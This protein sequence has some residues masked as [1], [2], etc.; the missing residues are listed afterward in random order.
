M[1]I[2]CGTDLS[3]D[4]RRSVAAADALARRFRAKLDLVHVMHRSLADTMAKAVREMH[5]EDCRLGLTELAAMLDDDARR[6]KTRLLTGNADEEL[7]RLGSG[8]DALFLVVGS[9]GHRGQGHWR[10]GSCA[11]RVAETSHT[12]TLVVRDE[13]AFTDWGKDDRVMRIMVA[14][15]FDGTGE[16]A[17]RAAARWAELGPCEI[18]VTHVDWP[19]EEARRH[20]Q[21]T[22]FFSTRNSPEVQRALERDV[23]ERAAKVLGREPDAV[24]VDGDYSRPD[25]HFAHLVNERCPDLVV[26]GTH[27]FHGL[28]RLRQNSFSRGLLH[29]CESNMLL[30]PLVHEAAASVPRTRRVLVA[31]D[32][33][34]LGN[35]A[36]PMAFAQVADGGTVHLVHVVDPFHAPSP[37]VPKYQT[38]GASAREHEQEANEFRR[39]LRQLVPPEAEARGIAVDVR[40]VEGEPL[41]ATICQLADRLDADLIC[42]GSHGRGGLSRLV[43]GSVANAVIARTHRPVLVVKSPAP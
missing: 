13:T 30:V 6:V 31:T 17:L 12:P 7:V 19:P 22:D 34:D 33:S 5:E 39:R 10:L 8:E 11:E 42:L 16:N 35:R 15:D 37:M 26:C 41:A 25:F 1:K 43:L 27:Q 24:L 18:T 4:S 21:R 3:P 32:F 14:W 2:I 38:H 40:V 28:K 20:G 23:L 29:N 9:V 36:V